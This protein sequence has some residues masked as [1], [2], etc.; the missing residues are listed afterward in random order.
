MC[1]AAWRDQSTRSFVTFGP[2][3]ELKKVEEQDRGAKKPKL[4][5]GLPNPSRNHSAT[6]HG[7]SIPILSKYCVYHSVYPSIYFYPPFTPPPARLTIPQD[8]AR[9]E[10]FWRRQAAGVGRPLLW[11]RAM[12]KEQQEFGGVG[13]FQG[14]D[15]DWLTLDTEDA[16]W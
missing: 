7:Q 8:T 6:N 3:Q 4:Q 16:P 14:D 1:R 9:W 12:E 15:D 13:I 10:R 2:Y 5:H 11:P